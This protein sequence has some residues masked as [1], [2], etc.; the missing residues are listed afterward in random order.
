MGTGS[1]RRPLSEL[2]E[3]LGRRSVQPVA[4]VSTLA[5]SRLKLMPTSRAKITSLSQAFVNSSQKTEWGY[6]AFVAR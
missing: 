3:T 4:Q 6:G 2:L 5:K 1:L